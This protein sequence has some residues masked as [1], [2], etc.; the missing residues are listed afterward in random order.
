MANTG[1][2]IISKYPCACHLV[3]LFQLEAAYLADL[4]VL[5]LDLGV[6]AEYD[7]HQN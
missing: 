2:M 7:N 6:V 4:A 3:E 5:N 1:P